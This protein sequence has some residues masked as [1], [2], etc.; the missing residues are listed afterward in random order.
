MRPHRSSGRRRY[1]GLRSSAPLRSSDPLRLL[2][3]APN[4]HRWFVGPRRRRPRR[5]T[6]RRR[7]VSH[8][9]RVHPGPSAHLGGTRRRIRGT[10]PLRLDPTSTPLPWC[11]ATRLHATTTVATTARSSSGQPLSR[12]GPRARIRSWSRPAGARCRSTMSRRSETGTA[13]SR[14]C[15]TNAAARDSDDV[16]S[17]TSMVPRPK[18]PLHAPARRT[19]APAIRWH[20]HRS[21]AAPPPPLRDRARRPS[22]RRRFCDRANPDRVPR[23]GTA[24]LA[25]PS[26]V[27]SPVGNRPAADRSRRRVWL[28]GAGSAPRWTGRSGVVTASSTAATAPG[29]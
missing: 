2:S 8:P 7:S 10:A 17:A 15:R 1:R 13:R 23:R 4:R 3:F 24:F 18:R 14:S 21:R 28:E 5:G 27:P 25:A 19:V 6:R 12:R 9:R 11:G 22:R 20:L 16:T 26:T 29:V